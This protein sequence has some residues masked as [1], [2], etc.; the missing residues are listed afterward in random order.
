MCRTVYCVTKIFDND[1]SFPEELGQPPWLPSKLQYSGDKKRRERKLQLL[2]AASLPS[3]W[4]DVVEHGTETCIECL[5]YSQVQSHKYR[6]LQ[7]EEEEI[8]NDD[9]CFIVSSYDGKEDFLVC[10]NEQ[11][12]LICLSC[13][14]RMFSGVS[15]AH[16]IRVCKH[17]KLGEKNL[18]FHSSSMMN[19]CGEPMENLFQGLPAAAIERAGRLN[20]CFSEKLFSETDMVSMEHADAEEPDEL[21]RGAG[22]LQNLPDSHCTL[23]SVVGRQTPLS[24]ELK[25]QCRMETEAFKIREAR[26]TDAAGKAARKWCTENVVL[27][28]FRELECKSAFSLASYSLR[29]SYRFNC[30]TFCSGRTEII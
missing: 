16:V 14:F 21:Q 3:L 26:R 27:K 18:F 6:V 30:D 2:F 15:C 12:K 1:V 24:Q 7:N 17:L 11:D 5:T 9:P 25:H 4:E 23:Q 19:S 22:I 29:L 13:T 8:P 20:D 10:F 28:F